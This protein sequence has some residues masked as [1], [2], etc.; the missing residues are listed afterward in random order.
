MQSVVLIRHAKSVAN[1]YKDGVSE[2]GH[3]GHYA[4]P[5]DEGVRHSLLNAQLSVRGVHG[6]RT[7]AGTLWQRISRLLIGRSIVLYTSPVKRALQTCLLS[8]DCDE[9]AA[10][11]TGDTSFRVIVMPALMEAGNTAENIGIELAAIQRCPDV[12][13]L[14]EALKL[15]FK[16]PP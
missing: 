2:E 5:F 7:H 10:I 8:L 9:A 13:Y 16:V 1:E 14:V 11:F 15:R 3:T 12:F 4:I 6:V